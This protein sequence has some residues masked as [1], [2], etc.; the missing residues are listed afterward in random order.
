MSSGLVTVANLEDDGYILP[1]RRWAYFDE[2]PIVSASPENI[3]E[4]LR[5]LV[6][7]PEL[8]RELGCA[9]REYAVKYH[10]YDSAQYLFQ[11]VVAF[12]QGERGSLLN[13]FHPLTSEHVRRRPMVK[14]PLVGNRVPT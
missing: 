5:T 8:R 11:E 10:A 1:F 4:V 13:L 2:C 6:T 9:S 7:R 14:H 12:V 3:Y